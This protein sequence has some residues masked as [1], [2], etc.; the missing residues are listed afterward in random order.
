MSNDKALKT[1]CT[2]ITEPTPEMV[3]AGALALA[4]YD[5]NVDTPDE[6]AVRVYLAME[7][8]RRMACSFP[9]PSQQ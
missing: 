1:N 4:N 2:E 7:E 9:P 6:G 5:R 8:R 3:E